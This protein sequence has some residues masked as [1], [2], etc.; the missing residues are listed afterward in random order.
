MGVEHHAD[1][2]KWS[3]HEIELAATGLYGN[4]YTEA[5]VTATFA[6]PG[7]VRLAVPGFWD[8]GDCFVVRFTPTVEGRW[9]YATSSA[10]AGLDGRTGA[11]T[12]APSRAGDRGFVRRAARYP[13]HFAHDDGGRHFMCGQ[14]YYGLLNNA[15]AGGGWRAAIDG[16]A[17]R[18]MNKVRLLLH[19]VTGNPFNPYPPTSPFAGDHDRPNLDHWRA[20][21]AVVAYLGA[22]GLVA[23][24]IL[25]VNR[26][27]NPGQVFGTPEQ[28]A[29]Y[30]RYALAR[31]AAYP[32][33]IWCLT[34]EWNYTGKDR[35]YWDG[36]GRL[37]RAE[38]P[39]AGADDRRRLLTI[40]Q[41]TRIDWQFG[42]AAWPTHVCFQYGVRNGQ[43]TRAD[44]W[45]DDPHNQA[46]HPH[47]DDWGHAGVRHNLAHGLPV[48]NDEYG[49][50]GEPE[51]RSAPGAPPLTR[52]KHRRILWGIYAAGGYAAA[53]DKTTYD[54]GRPYM[55]ANWHDTAE[56]GDIARLVAF[57]TGRE[58]AYWRMAAANDLVRAGERVYVLAE[59]GRQYVIYA[60]AGGAF[61][62]DL[63][64]GDYHARRYDPRTGAAVALGAVRGAG[65]RSFS[66]PD[67]DDWVVYLIASD[68]GPTS[69]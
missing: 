16:S 18:G 28:D 54:D 64:A 21:D 6:G 17:A 62:I 23:D 65:A 12:C 9:T 30:L 32:N 19:G 33:V 55:S 44:E 47:G 25:F 69:E 26:A 56:Y 66:L 67:H 63:A 35:A 5:G 37:A 3:V 1:V 58:I 36:L 42:A 13:R 52:A 40:H 4:P 27:V 49:Y 50:I 43:R 31:Y 61:A 7:G 39:W 29:R 14:T 51:D 24:L 20:L 15:V 48:V 10:D 53:G 68:S 45:A 60:A 22:R 41:Q 46:R 57:F 38:D 34:N 11:L 59:P 2:P 8:G